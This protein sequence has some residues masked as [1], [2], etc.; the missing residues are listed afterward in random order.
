[1]SKHSVADLMNSEV[2]CLRPEMTVR[3]AEQLFDEKRIGGAPV[4]DDSGEP[5]GVV[6]QRD[7]IRHQA[8]PGTAGSTGR[9]YTDVE[10]YRD[11]ESAPVDTSSTPVSQVMTPDVLC[12]ERD[13][14]VADAARAMRHHRIH[15]LLVTQQGVLVGIL[16]ALDLLAALEEPGA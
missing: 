5:V 13:A 14:D 8:E 6:S 9:F 15:R 16:S 4:V 2:V 3:Q 10:D 1:M 12:I 7:L 11:L